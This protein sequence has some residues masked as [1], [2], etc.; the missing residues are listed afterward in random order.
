MKMIIGLLPDVSAVEILLNNLAEAEFDL[1]E[2]SVIA[3]DSRQRKAIA[4]EGGPLKGATLGTLAD[5]LVEAGLPAEDARL[6]RNAVA[7]G[8]VLVAMAVPPEAEK[9]A[10]E[11]F[12][13]HAAQ[14][15]GE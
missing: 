8:K 7:E 3:R 2:V 11:M 15:I 1:R 9:A 6:C 14:L 5:R 10:K 13:D 4:K 12:Q